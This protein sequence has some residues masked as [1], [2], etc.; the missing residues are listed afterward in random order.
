MGSGSTGVAAIKEK[1]KFI[2]METDDH[3]FNVAHQRIA[4]ARATPQQD[5]LEL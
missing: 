2:G 3:W 5:E 4:L 1:R